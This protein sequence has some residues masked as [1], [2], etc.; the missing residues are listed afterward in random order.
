MQ[1]G[2]RIYP[3][4]PMPGQHL[5]KPGREDATHAKLLNIEGRLHESCRK[6]TTEAATD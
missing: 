4:P 1:A 2:A 3:E 5:K 6:F